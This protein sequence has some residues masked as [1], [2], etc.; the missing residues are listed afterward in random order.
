MYKSPINIYYQQQNEM[1][2]K[3]VKDVNNDTERKVIEYITSIGIDVNK[4]ELIKALRYDREQ[5]EKGYQ[6]GLNAD[7]W[8]FMEDKEPETNKRYLT[9][10]ENG[11]M[12]VGQWTNWGWMFGY[13]VKD[14]IAWQELPL[15]PN[16]NL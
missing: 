6:D 7:K 9:L 12:N 11:D 3:I 8:I 5:Y 1:I 15:K 16:K 4:E 10:H 2:D 13:Y 14:V